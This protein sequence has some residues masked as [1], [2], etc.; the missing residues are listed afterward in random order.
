MKKQNPARRFTSIFLILGLAFLTIG[1]A[2]DQTAFTW[3]AIA[4]VVVSLLS[5]GRWLRP[6][7]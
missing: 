6:R 5:G 1:I 7:K 2:T 3:I 4:F